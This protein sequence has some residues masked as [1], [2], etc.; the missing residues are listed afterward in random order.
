[1]RKTLAT[2]KS[3]VP[4]SSALTLALESSDIAAEPRLTQSRPS[5]AG[6]DLYAERC[7]LGICVH[8]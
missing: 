8:A 1:M 7:D 2:P 3:V 4:D 5:A 6:T